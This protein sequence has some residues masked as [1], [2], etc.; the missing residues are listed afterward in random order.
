MPER[1]R[2]GK[3]RDSSQSPTVTAIRMPAIMKALFRRGG[4]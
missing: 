2:S 4:G 3:A 1:V